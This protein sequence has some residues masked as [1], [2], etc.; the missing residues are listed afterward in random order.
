MFGPC[1]ADVCPLVSAE[2]R[3]RDADDDDDDVDDGDDA[4]G[5]LSR[6]SSRLR[7]LER[8]AAVDSVGTLA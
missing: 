2:A 3:R 6:L 7:L 4:A 5:R 1:A 8:A